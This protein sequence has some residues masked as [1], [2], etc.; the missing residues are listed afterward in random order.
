VL[1]LGLLFLLP[2]IAKPFVLYLRP[3]MLFS[4]IKDNADKK[5]SRKMNKMRWKFKIKPSIYRALLL[6][7]SVLMSSALM[8]QPV[9][10]KT[11]DHLIELSNFTGMIAQSNQNMRPMFD[12]QAEDIL[13]NNLG[14]LELSTEQKLVAQKI[15]LLLQKT[16]EAII[17]NPKFLHM[18]RK[19]FQQT[20]TEE[21]A[22]AY[23]QFLS[24]PMGQS[25]NRKS[26]V[27]TNNILQET[28]AISNEILNQPLQ[29]QR[30]NE[31]LTS[32]IQP[33]LLKTKS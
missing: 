21:E 1:F 29:M 9:Q 30:F 31:Q 26:S 3:V 2:Y 15:S 8:A 13:K 33:L 11:L 5:I 7:T 10:E 17:S 4:L 22:Q 25:I 24:T 28:L 6:S 23:I 27:M 20:Y 16:N 14:V 18:I 19:N 12:A 32:L